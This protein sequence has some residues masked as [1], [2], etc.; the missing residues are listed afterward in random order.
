MVAAQPG[1]PLVTAD[2]SDDRVE[3]L[4]AGP[5]QEPDARLPGARRQHLSHR[6]ARGG[7]EVYEVL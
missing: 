2:A 3:A 1:K 4:C 5:L 6:S 7:L